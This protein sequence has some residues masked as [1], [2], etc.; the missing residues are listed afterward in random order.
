MDKSNGYENRAA[1]FIRRRSKG[2]D[3]IGAQSVRHWARSLPPKA[4]VL[5]VGCGTGD[6]ISQ[7][8]VYEGLSVYAI[9]ASPSMVEIFKQNCSK[10]EM[11]R[12]RYSTGTGIAWSGPWGFLSGSLEAIDI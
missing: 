10:M 3:G 1:I 8:L 12:C 6:P 2:I 11:G 7:V 4:T 5:D 9:D